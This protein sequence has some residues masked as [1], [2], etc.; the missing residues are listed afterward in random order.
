M[1][2]SLRRELSSKSDP[3]QGCFGDQS[4]PAKM[5]NRWPVIKAGP[6]AHIVCE[7]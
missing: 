6:D 3:V 1:D 5:Q 7:T 2:K 4:R